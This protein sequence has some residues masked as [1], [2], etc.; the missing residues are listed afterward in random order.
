MGLPYIQRRLCRTLWT[1]GSE[2]DR[3]IG[4]SLPLLCLV[5]RHQVH[6]GCPSPESETN[7]ECFWTQPAGLE[8]TGMRAQKSFS[9][10]TPVGLLFPLPDVPRDTVIL[11]RCVVQLQAVTSN[12]NQVSRR[13]L[14]MTTH[15]VFL[16]RP[17]RP[18]SAPVRPLD[19]GGLIGVRCLLCLLLSKEPSPDCLV[20][21]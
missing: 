11:K 3:V 9:D 18:R 14:A 2:P 5:I 19:N 10:V 17:P 21:G 12:R 1:T 16:G 7:E 4:R 8:K 15:H 20:G 13:Y 6:C